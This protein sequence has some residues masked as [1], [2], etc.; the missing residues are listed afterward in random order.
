MVCHAVRAL[1]DVGVTEAVL[2]TDDPGPFRGLLGTGSGWPIYYER[3][4]RA[5]GVAHA[6]ALAHRML[7]RSE[8][9]AVILADNLWGSSL[10]RVA[11]GFET[12]AKVALHC[13]TA[14]DPILHESGV[15]RLSMTGEIMEIV[16]KPTEPPSTYVATGFYCFDVTVW[17]RLKKLQPSARGELEITDL[18]NLYAADDELDYTVI[19]GWWMDA[20]SSIQAYY[21]ACDKV[22]S[23]DLAN[24]LARGV[25]AT[26]KP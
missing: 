8:P 17:D 10:R 13:R 9:V 12:G 1:A 22:R 5:G 21:A 2:V 14:G 15:P 4:A 25:R 26:I 20:G 6:L 18:L 23:E 7:P 24:R 16:E 3:Q 19:S 11:N